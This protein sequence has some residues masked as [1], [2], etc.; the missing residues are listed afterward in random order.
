MRQQLV[1]RKCTGNIAK[2]GVSRLRGWGPKYFTTN[3]LET[4][5]RGQWTSR[6]NFLSNQNDWEF[7][8]V[9]LYITC[10]QLWH[11]FIS[12][13]L[14]ARFLSP[15]TFIRPVV[16]TA[17]GIKVVVSGICPATSWV[18]MRRRRSLLT[19]FRRFHLVV[20]SDQYRLDMITGGL[21]G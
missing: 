12:R 3:W 5:N 15:C 21:L 4:A 1:M 14:Q 10:W 2:S 13:I 17:S 7:C 16:T 20:T 19:G 18:T 6:R 11:P 9:R 8:A